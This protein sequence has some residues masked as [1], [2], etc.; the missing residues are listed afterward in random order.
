MSVTRLSQ[1]VNIKNHKLL[2][3]PDQVK[4][5]QEKN[6]RAFELNKGVFLLHLTVCIKKEVFF[7]LK[8][9]IISLWF[10]KLAIC[11]IRLYI[12]MLGKRSKRSLSS[13]KGLNFLLSIIVSGTFYKIW[14]RQS[15]VLQGLW[16]GMKMQPQNDCS[17]IYHLKADADAVLY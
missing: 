3:K 15:N 2:L 9:D 17:I 7:P 13:A 10:M 4:K 12:S 11:S 8:N 1:V 16:G 5:K 6:Q 14:F